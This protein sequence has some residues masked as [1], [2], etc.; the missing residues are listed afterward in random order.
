[1]VHVSPAPIAI[2]ADGQQL[3]P[4]TTPSSPSVTS[5]S[6]DSPSP[7]LLAIHASPDPAH[8][9]FILTVGDQRLWSDIQWKCSH[10]EET[11]WST[12]SFDDSSWGLCH[13]VGSYD[14][15]LGPAI[16]TKAKWIWGDDASSQTAKCRMPL[17]TRT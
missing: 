7:R 9:G 8:A 11:S 5:F 6:L 1:M 17:P 10:T 15:N 4:I 13:V 14:D 2:Y 12:V 16:H 3:T